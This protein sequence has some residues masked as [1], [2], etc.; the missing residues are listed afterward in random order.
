M[1]VLSS[2]NGESPSLRE[3]GPQL[4]QCLEGVGV[5]IRGVSFAYDGR[6]VLDDVSLEVLP[7]EM[8]ALLGPNGSGKT[9]LLKVILGLLRPKQ[10]RV[11]LDGHPV[12]ELSRK[13]IAQQVAVVPQQF[14][15]PFAFTVEEV[16]MLGRTPH[17]RPLVEE[18]PGDRAWVR[19][20]LEISGLGPLAGRPFNELSGG[21]RQKVVMALA[22]AQQPRVLLLDEPVAHLDIRHQ[23]E[24][25]EVVQR[26]NRE[27]GIT[28][29]A[30][31]HDLNL[32]CLYFDRLLLLHKG[33][34]FADGTPGQVITTENLE[35][36]FGARVEV[37]PHPSAPVPCV[38]MLPGT[39]TPR[40]DSR[41]GT[42]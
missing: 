39:S 27:Q 26:L 6:A 11:F 35:G 31:M 9:T 13:H 16:V 33:Q 22:L 19:A 8:V 42:G 21:E 29:V 30:A 4:P 3:I 36:V 34:V 37:V 14:H 1:N 17:L 23:A 28:V 12:T 20:A 32:A 7:G 18:G 40:V 15:M 38:V 24:A 10:G 5:H 25:L 2:P 41:R